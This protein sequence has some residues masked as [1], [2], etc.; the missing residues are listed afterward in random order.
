MEQLASSQNNHY[1]EDGGSMDLSKASHHLPDC[2]ATSL[3]PNKHRVTLKIADDM[4]AET[5]GDV[6]NSTRL[7]TFKGKFLICSRNRTRGPLQVPHVLWRR[8][9]PAV[10]EERESF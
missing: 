3:H 2:T 6:Q 1:S 9:T 7:N 5:S 10:K 4:F 8:K